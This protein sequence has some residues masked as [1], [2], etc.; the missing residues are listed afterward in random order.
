[1]G[2]YMFKLKELII[3][4]VLSYFSHISIAGCTCQYNSQGQLISVCGECAERILNSNRSE[5]FDSNLEN[6]YSLNPLGILS[7]GLKYIAR[8]R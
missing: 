8:G 3:L 2:I 5:D 7:I 4:I 1:M 6:S